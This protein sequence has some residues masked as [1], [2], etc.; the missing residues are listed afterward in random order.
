MGICGPLLTWF[1]NYLSDRRQTVVIRG[2][3]SDEGFIKA[4]V[5]QGSILGPLLFLIYIND[6]TLVTESKM[7][8][9][10]DDTSIYVD[11]E[12]AEPATIQLNQDLKAIK[13]WANQWLV[14]FS[15]PKTKLLTCSYKKK[16]YPDVIFNNSV[17][18]TVDSHKH[19]GLVLSSN[20]QWGNHIDMILSSVAPMSDIL[21][22]LKYDLDRLSIE[23]TYFTFIRPKLEYACIIWDNC[24]NQDRDRIESFQ[25]DIARV[26]TGARKGT[27][28]ASLY[29]ETNW[30]PLSERRKIFRL[31]KLSKIEEGSCPS[32]MTE[33][34]PDKIESIRPSSRN[35]SNFQNFKCRT[36]TFKRSFYPNSTSDWN[37]LPLEAR[38]TS[39]F[40]QEMR[41][42]CNPLYYEGSRLNNIKHAQLRMNCSKLNAHLFSLHVH[43]TEQCACGH[44]IE[45]TSHYLL[46]CPLYGTSREKLFIEVRHMDIGIDIDI[47][48]YGDDSHSFD[49]NRRIFQEVHRFISETGRL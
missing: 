27:S 1:V 23:R 31:K 4:G 47:L 40:T 21:K 39:H 15:A 33:L 35:A 32:Y 34:L 43:D 44:L 14:N 29:N 20:L 17:L 22:R 5:P 38:S 24:S 30:M 11:F 42:K 2:Q 8:L 3:K 41:T 18:E 25:L 26:V 28:H 19:L 36:E 16:D 46:H 12:D 7:K 10:A 37:S 48:L 13:E 6:I 9:F 49:I 45:D